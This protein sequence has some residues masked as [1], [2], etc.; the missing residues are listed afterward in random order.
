MREAGVGPVL[1]RTAVVLVFLC[2]AILF[3][4]GLARRFFPSA[5]QAAAPAKESLPW[6]HDLAQARQRARA[7]NKRLLVDAWAEWCAACRELD[8]KTF[9]R[10][11][12]RAALRDW[13][14]GQAGL[15]S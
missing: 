5:P 7:E 11:D 3:Y 12:V 9:S 1:V 2:G 14:S 6:L 13:I 4:Q 8:E 15:H 10:D